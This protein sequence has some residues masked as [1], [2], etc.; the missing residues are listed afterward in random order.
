MCE[1][2]I[3]PLLASQRREPDGAA[4]LVD[5]HDLTD[6]ALAGRDLV[7][8]LSS[9]Q[10]VEV[11]V[12]PVVALRV[13]DDFVRGPEHLPAS[14]RLVL[15]RYRLIEDS[16]YGA[17]R[18]LGAREHRLLVVAGSGHEREPGAVGTPLVVVHRD[19]VAQS[20]TVI[21]RHHL[22]ADDASAVHLDD[23]T[24]EH[25]QDAV[26]GEREPPG[27]EHRV[28]HASLDVVVET[29]VA[30]V[31]L[32]RRDLLGI[33]GP[34]Q[35]RAIAGAPAGVVGGVAEVL[36]AV[37]GEGP[38]LSR[39]DIAHPQVPVPNEDGVLSVR[40]E[41]GIARGASAPAATAPTAASST[42]TGRS[43]VRRVGDSG[44]VASLGVTDDA[45]ALGGIY[46]H[47]LGSARSRVAVPEA[48]V[49]HPVRGHVSAND[50]RRH[51]LR[52]K[53]FGAGV[54]GGGEG[55][56]LLSHARD[57]GHQA[58]HQ[59]REPTKCD[60]TIQTRAHADLSCRYGRSVCAPYE[61]MWPVERDGLR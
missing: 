54:V 35:D 24:M 46:E 10:V 31:L 48:I 36:D 16:A 22:Q 56:G 29:D 43:R 58:C 11:E 55:A 45:S 6:G 15:S 28:A 47:G 2:R 41:H 33:G 27:A 51:V 9:L 60:G 42:T 61:G 7:L 8:E 52:Q 5:S 21:I 23:H 1:V 12:A 53:L 26:A 59:G 14:P 39:C 49:R 50:E 34:E 32:V 20:S 25:R 30:F 37:G 19:V 13:P 38:L 18:R 40:R 44:T 3:L 57:G 4:L 17:G